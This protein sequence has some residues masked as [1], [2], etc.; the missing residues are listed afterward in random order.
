MKTARTYY[1]LTFA[2]LTLALVLAPGLIAANF[3]WSGAS[4]T[5]LLWATAGNWTPGGPPGT[6]DEAQFSNPGA[7]NDQALVS[8]VISA[9]TT[10]ERL[11]IGPTTGLF[12]QPNPIHHIL[13]NPGVTLTVAGTAHNGNGP[14]GSVPDATA[15]I[16]NVLSTFYVG[17]KGEVASTTTV[18]NVISGGGTL[19]VSNPNNELNVRQ[20]WGA[21]GAEHWAVLDLSGLDTFH[22]NLGRI[23]IGDG[24]RGLLR[25]AQGLVRLAKTNNITL[26]G[27]NF[28]DNVQLVVANND[29]NNNGMT[30]ASR[31]YFGQQNTLAIDEILIGGRK[32]DGRV[33]FDDGLVN[34]SLKLRGAD[35]VGRTRALR[36]GDTSD[37]GGSTAPAGYLDLSGGTVDILAD[38]IIVGK[39]QFQA[40]A[41]TAA[42]TLTLGAGTVDVN[43]LELA[44]HLAPDAAHNASGILTLNGTRVTVNN[45]LRL[46][47]YSGAAATRTRTATVNIGT[48]GLLNVLGAYTNNG[49]VN[50]NLTGGALSLPAGSRITAASVTVDGGA[51]SNAASLT[52]TNT[53][54]ALT[55]VNGAIIT[56]NPAFDMG[57][58]GGTVWDLNSAGTGF[59][60]G[61]SLSGA[62]QVQGNITQAPGA[63]IS[64]GGANRGRMLTFLNNLTLNH[65]GKLPIDLSTNVA[66]GA[67]DLVTVA[68]VL[69]LNGTNDVPLN[70]LGA[71]LDTNPGGYPIIQAAGGIVGTAANLK[72]AGTLAQ[73]RFSFAFDTTATPGT[74]LLKVGG[75]P[76][77]SLTWVGDGA[78]N[79]WDING[80]NNWNDG[81]GA[82]KFFNL[83]NVTFTDAG[84]ATPAVNL[85]GAL[86]PGSM[87]VNNPTK[88]YTFNGTGGIV[89]GGSLTKSGTGSLTFNNVGDNGFAG[90]VT[91]S[92]GVVTF[93]NTGLNT[94]GD[95]LAV[96]GGSATLSGD[97]ANNFAGLGGL[98]VGTGAALTMANVGENTFDAGAIQ[99][100]GT[101]SFNNTVDAI[102]NGNISG[103]GTLIKA[104]TNTLTLGGLNNGLSSIVQI[105]AGTIKATSGSAL[106]VGGVTIA[107]GA[108][109]DV[110]GQNLS[111]LAAATVVAGAGPTGL[112]AI[113]NNGAPQESALVNVTMT[114]HTTFGGAGPWNPDPVVNSGRMDIRGSLSTGGQPYNL[115]KV[116]LNQMTLRD[117]TVDPALGDLDVK[118]GALVFQGTT[119]TMGDATK[120]L[121]V[122]AGATL[123]FFGPGA[124]WDKKIVLHGDGVTPTLHDWN[125]ANTIIGPVTLNG[126]CVVGEVPLVR[127]AP[128]SIALLG[129]VSGSGG[130]T[131]NS[132]VDSLVLGG[133]NTYTGATVINGG[134]LSVIGEGTIATTPSITLAAGTTLDASTRTD[135]TFRLASG[136]TLQGNGTV[137]GTFIATAGSTMSPGTSIGALSFS[138]NVTLGGTVHLELN[139]AT[140]TNDFILAPVGVTMNN[141]I[142]VLTNISGSLLDQ[143]VFTLFSAPPM[144]GNFTIQPA[145]PGPGQTWNTGNLLSE[146]WIRVVG[147]P[148]TPSPHPHIVSVVLSGLNLVVSGTNG[149]PSGD[150]YVLAGTNVGQP[151]GTWERIATNSFNSGSFSFT[152]VVNPGTPQRFLILQ[153]P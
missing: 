95:G 74:I 79:N 94:F 77:E 25:R 122:R 150:Y 99:L 18:T 40:G 69:T 97:N 76:P 118:S 45:L 131:K 75:S 124:N 13:I 121:T 109:L 120:T 67:S 87:T 49:I 116:G 78:A 8:T 92:N 1:H 81:S 12:N 60:I 132:V 142:I 51:I 15:P 2:V 153:L 103:A 30:R 84:S 140:G 53:G 148:S 102:L 64:A 52:V 104:N 90:L 145:T 107:N 147:S 151:R 138:N 23:R 143:Q 43:T 16:T 82:D 42:G 50:L 63:T 135:A 128:V 73:S 59:T 100:D 7:T 137:N 28:A 34:P 98:I 112:G 113:V 24:E 86:V 141:A 55:L 105:N 62:G 36:I 41:G 3:T 149:T 91:V 70:T 88:N 57:L 68:G 72:P 114:G 61:N 146:G 17:T 22:A 65:G 11:W 37:Q 117:L 80:A 126:N 38:T 32:Q 133:T 10:I 44:Y 136:Q 111:L 127:G 83:D 110:N 27:T 6:L 152:N 85:V 4:G 39:G 58:D 21:G 71:S 123:S 93:S 29:E 14:L 139:A 19:F 125:G 101:L 48:G 46:G 144:S 129:A 89:S 54:A 119:D 47:R 96:Y 66:D 106:G 5:G 35:G 56:G 9:S 134:T 130:F 20:N 31:L 26:T 33:A 115:T 108:A